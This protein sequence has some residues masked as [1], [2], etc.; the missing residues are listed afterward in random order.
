MHPRVFHEIM[1]DEDSI[2]YVTLD[3]QNGMNRIANFPI[4]I[5]PSVDEYEIV[6]L[7]GGV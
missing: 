5:N 7:L 6:E 1:N 3:L 4:E 2:K